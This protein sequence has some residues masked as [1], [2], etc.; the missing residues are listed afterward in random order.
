MKQYHRFLSLLLVFA[1]AISLPF[2][3]ATIAHAADKV[4]YPIDHTEA[5]LASRVAQRVSGG[6][7]VASMATIEAYMYGATSD[8]DKDLV[9]DALIAANGDDDY[10]NWGDA[11]FLTNYDSINWEDV[12]IQLAQGTPCIIHRPANDSQPQHWSVVAGYHGSSAQLE[13][14]RFLVVEVNESAG[15]A[16]QTVAQWRGS[17]E[18]DRYSWRGS[19]IA[20]TNVTGIRFAIN[21]P[22]VIKEYGVAHRVY[23]HIVSDADLT[24]IEVTI[25]R[26]DSGEVMFS[27]TLTPNSRSY[28]ISALDSAMTYSS[29]P[30]GTY[31]Y[32]VYA[33]NAQGAE[34][35]YGVY[36]E[37]SSS[38]PQEKPDPVYSFHF[39]ANGGS[40]TMDSLSLRQGDAL[41][42][43]VSAMSHQASGFGG[44]YLRRSDGT[45]YTTAKLWLNDDE[46]DAEGYN[47]YL[48]EDGYSCI[49]DAWFLRDAAVLP[50]YTFVAYWP[51]A[52]SDNPSAP[53]EPIEPPDPSEPET[54]VSLTRIYGDSRY[55][56]AFEIANTLKEALDVTAFENIIVASGTGFADA[57]AGSYLA[58][59][60]NAPILLTNGTNIADLLAYIQENL[61]EDGTVYILGGTAAVPDAV[62][63]ALDS[64][65]IQMLRLAG[66]TRYETNLEILRSMDMTAGL[67]ILVCSGADYAD[68]LSASATGLPI[69]LVNSA[70]ET[71]SANQTAFLE[72]LTNC[73]FTIIGGPAAVP[74]AL[75]AALLSYGDV[76]RISG[77]TRE[78][79]SV[80]MAE[81]YFQNPERV[82]L[83]YSRNF[84][85]GLCG[86]PLAYLLGAPLILVNAG[87]ETAAAGYV[88]ETPI[89]SALILGGPAAITDSTIRTIFPE[90]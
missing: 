71:L 23:G 38:Y 16:I 69:L 61:S 22:P 36:F 64:A 56:T 28:D 84:P 40:G 72:K 37:I 21:H 24:R 51:N 26:L 41:E 55:D 27:K 63:S 7:A 59:S 32:T 65:G 68:A 77:S 74:E 8:A 75:E 76:G 1:M 2:P 58:A 13:P 12:Y 39:D 54:E 33:R 60:K 14:D 57:L 90:N 87:Q 29:W 48:F 3:L 18:V 20:Y 70:A 35:M 46:I 82:I 79:T 66:S 5:V 53:S 17:A 9:Y 10:A 42:L 25:A 89:T 73:R 15:E 83:A 31:Y 80:Q 45:W 4:Y 81:T 62:A 19:G 67:E 47:R 85:D 52:G 30:E 34:E 78:S 88:A 11:G 50:E 44:W 49:M 86:G 43:P 6:C